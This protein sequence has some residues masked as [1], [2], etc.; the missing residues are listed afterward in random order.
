MNTPPPIKRKDRWQ[1]RLLLVLLST[2]LGLL[3]LE[4]AVRVGSALF[5][6]LMLAR[7]A[8]L[9]WRHG[10][11]RSKYFTNEHGERNLV[12]LN[13]FGHR[14]RAHGVARTPGKYRVLVLGDSFTEGV[15]AGE[16]E[17][18]THLLEASGRNLEVLNTGVSSWGTVQEYLY[19]REHG[20]RFQ[21]DLVLL[22]YYAND[23]TD[24]CIPYSPGI[25]PRP[26]AFIRE[27]AVE[28]AEDY[29]DSRFVRFLPP[30][31]F[32]SFL[33]RNSLLFYALVERL[34]RPVRMAEYRRILIQ[35]EKALVPEE[36][37]RIG[38]SLISR[39]HSLVAPKGIA[40]AVVLVPSRTI[41][42]QGG[43]EWYDEIEEF[44]SANGVPCLSLLDAMIRAQTQGRRPYFENDIH[45]TPEGHAIAAEAIAPFLGGVRGNVSR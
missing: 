42:R 6:P 19:L 8:R 13:E 1:R 36:T 24:N 31:P 17:V 4:G 40:L 23:R 38:L 37:R 20:L 26:H 22:M 11:N 35:E 5:Y 3:L 25:G 41:L 32:R 43:D 16:E 12:V 21:P 30:V 14:G 15:A 10:T 39:I 9:G 7:D 18:F 27:G 44:C 33:S 28:I 2:L 29:D 45:W 34:W